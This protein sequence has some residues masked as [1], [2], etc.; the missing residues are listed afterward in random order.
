MAIKTKYLQ[1]Y[2]NSDEEVLNVISKM[3]EQAGVNQDKINK[4]CDLKFISDNCY[5]I[6]TNLEQVREENTEL[7]VNGISFYVSKL[8]RNEIS[9]MLVKLHIA[10]NADTSI[11]VQVALDEEVYNWLITEFSTTEPILSLATY[12]LLTYITFYIFKSK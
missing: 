11:R 12:T 5:F 8:N 2:L 7:N 4:A 1:N 9:E 6:S 3:I 10:I